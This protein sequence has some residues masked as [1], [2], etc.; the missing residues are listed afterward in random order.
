MVVTC[1]SDENVA[2]D[3]ARLLIL[4]EPTGQFDPHLPEPEPEPGP[5][6]LSPHYFLGRLGQH[7][8]DLTWP[9]TKRQ[10]TPFWE[11][12]FQRQERSDHLECLPHRPPGTFFAAAESA[13]T[14]GDRAP[15]PIVFGAARNPFLQIFGHDLTAPIFRFD[16]FDLHSRIQMPWISEEIH[17]CSRIPQ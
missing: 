6:L 4:S 2:I 1:W 5:K 17:I 11:S 14:N 10:A 7:K 9:K 8:L 13:E 12:M 3:M 16:F 15:V